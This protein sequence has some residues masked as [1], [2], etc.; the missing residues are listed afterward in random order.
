MA[1]EIPAAPIE[2]LR[3]VSP[4]GAAG[5][6][7]LREGIAKAGPLDYQTIE[8]IL[9]GA[10]VATGYEDAIKIHAKRLI[11]LGV[12]K[13]AVRQAIQVPFGATAT[14]VDVTRALAWLDEIVN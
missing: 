6:K 12:S 11:D 3:K 9:L 13:E 7:A 1:K 10:F 8:F 5:F 4:T 2:Y 14:L